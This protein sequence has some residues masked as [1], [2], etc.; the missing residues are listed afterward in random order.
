MKRV[1]GIF[2]LF[3]S[4]QSF[5]QEAILKEFAESRRDFKICLYPSTLRM[6]NIKKDPA[7]NELVNGIEK[8][9]IYRLD[10]ST[11]ATKEYTNWTNEY[12]DNDFEEYMSM[13][14]AMNLIIL[15]KEDAEYVGVTGSNGQ[16]IAFYLRG[17]IAFEKIPKLIQTFEG[18]DILSLLTDQLGN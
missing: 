8:L 5:G 4:I 3:F 2:L 15:G 18:G 11:V 1:L 16:V 12:L 6:M 10:S 14:G 9:L 7:F 17:A 13:T